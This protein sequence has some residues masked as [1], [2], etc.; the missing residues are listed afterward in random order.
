MR[1]GAF[2]TGSEG[3]RFLRKAALAEPVSLSEG[4]IRVRIN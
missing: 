1:E 4:R 2:I 3:N